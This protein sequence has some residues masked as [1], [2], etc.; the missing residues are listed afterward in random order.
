MRTYV[1]AL[2]FAQAEVK[3]PTQNWHW[4]CQRFTRITV[5]ADAWA[6]TATQAWN[7]I[8]AAHKH[9]SY[10]PPAGA[11]AYYG[12]NN[13]DGHAVFSEG[14]GWIFTTDYQIAG[15]VGRVKWDY[16]VKQ[17][18]MKYRGWIDWT[19]SGPIQ[20]KPAPRILSF[21]KPKPAPRLWG[22]DVSGWQGYVNWNA[23][24]QAG[25]GFGFAKVSQGYSVDSYWHS[26]WGQMRKYLKVRGGYHFMAVNTDPVN[27]ARIFIAQFGKILPG[28]LMILDAEDVYASDH[29]N[30]VHT[31]AWIKAFLAEEIRLTGLPPH[32]FPIYT[33]QWWWDPATNG[34]PI[35]GHAL[36][37][38]AYCAEKNIQLPSG[39]GPWHFWQ[40]TDKAKTAGIGGGHDQSVY[41]FSQATLHQLAGLTA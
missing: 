15:H 25:A 1:Q 41:R 5:G 9:T 35:V 13:S 36:W 37:V 7:S 8:P 10:P 21:L 40:F 38:A 23:V 34:M 22:P 19:P 24:V 29:I 17:W 3:K 2:A 26:N 28:D 32:R 18:G 4:M 27:A 16:P 39:L 33:G 6:P 20:F 11:I 12:D 31:T 30:T 14:A